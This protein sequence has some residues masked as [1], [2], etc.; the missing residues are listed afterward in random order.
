VNR[1]IRVAQVGLGP[2]GKMIARHIL[3]ERKGIK[4]V[5]AV[6]I[7]PDLAGMDLGEAIG[8]ERKVGVK[9]GADAAKVFK[10]SRPDIAIYTTTSFAKDAFKQL[11]A[12]IAAGVDVI[13]TCEQLSYP[14]FAEPKL[15]AKYDKL[16]RAAGVSILGTGINPGFLMDARPIMLTAACTEVKRVEITRRMDASL[17]RKPFQKKIGASLTPAEFKRYMKEGKITGHVGLEESLCLIA[18]ALDWPLDTV[19]VEK[20]EPVIAEA[21][22]SSPFYKVKKGQVKGV[23]Q[24]AYGVIEGEPVIKLSFA[25]YL[26]ADPSYD[27]VYIEGTPEIRA[28]VSPCWHGDHGTVAMV[29]NLIPTVLNAPPGVIT[30]NDLVTISYKGGEM[31]R[32]VQG[33]K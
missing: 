31:S 21:P 28:R 4:Y 18:A 29:A 13:S 1:D 8:L 25:A 32:F 16:A 23:R 15:A 30:M 33:K 19:V 3:N 10:A 14:Y 2:L 5:G 11:E 9:V 24:E 27:E 17:R 22:V 12:A 7:S 26:G 6:D 20:A